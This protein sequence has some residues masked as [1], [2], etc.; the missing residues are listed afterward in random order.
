MALP[1]VLFLESCTAVLSVPLVFFVVFFFVGTCVVLT[2]ICGLYKIVSAKQLHNV[3]LT[4]ETPNWQITF[5][6][7]FTVDNPSPS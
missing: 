5:I 3:F 7:N 2:L 1:D 6:E 4:L